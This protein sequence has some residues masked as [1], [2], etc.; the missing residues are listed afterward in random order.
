MPFNRQATPQVATPQEATPLHASITCCDLSVFKHLRVFHTPLLAFVFC[1]SYPFLFPWWSFPQEQK[2]MEVLVTR[3]GK[4][5]LV[6][7]HYSAKKKLF[8]WNYGYLNIHIALTKSKTVVKGCCR[9]NL[10]RGNLDTFIFNN[11]NTLQLQYYSIKCG[12][13]YANKIFDIYL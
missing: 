12:H 13:C 4:V 3:K 11:Y 1:K 2:N 9:W 8:Q 10:L 5:W 7:R 6:S